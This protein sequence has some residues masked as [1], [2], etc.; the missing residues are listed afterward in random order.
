MTYCCDCGDKIEADTLCF[1]IA[2][3]YYCPRCI[4][5][6][7]VLADTDAV[8]IPSYE[9]HVETAHRHG[10]FIEKTV[11]TTERSGRYDRTEIR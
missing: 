10:R 11:T 5:D 8:R 6:A 9:I 4:R 1:Y 3:R 2:Y 7:A